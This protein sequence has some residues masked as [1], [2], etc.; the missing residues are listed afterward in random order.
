[1]D[2]RSIDITWAGL[3]RVF[4]II[5][6]L[7]LMYSAGDVLLAV[8]LAIILSAA[9]DLPVTYL[10]KKKVDAFANVLSTNS[11]NEK[12]SDCIR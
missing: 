3:W 9:F 2:S 6:V 11:I 5:L 7:W 4:T 8:L 10:E 1:M 12:F